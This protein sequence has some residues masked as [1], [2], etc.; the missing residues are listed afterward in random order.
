MELRGLSAINQE[1][2]ILQILQTLIGLAYFFPPAAFV[3]FARKRENSLH[4][5]PFGSLAYSSLY[6]ECAILQ[7][8]GRF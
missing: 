6:V 1:V 8:A 2:H 4:I 3:Y 7:R 5:G